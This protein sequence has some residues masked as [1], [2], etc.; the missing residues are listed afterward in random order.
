MVAFSLSVVKMWLPVVCGDYNNIFE[1]PEATAA[2]SGKIS[3][4]ICEP[5]CHKTKGSTALH[6]EFIL[7][8]WD[9][10]CHVPIVDQ[11]F[12]SRVLL[13]LVKRLTSKP[14][15]DPSFHSSMLLHH[16]YP[17]TWLNSDHSPFSH[18]VPANTFTVFCD[19]Y[20]S[21]AWCDR[22]PSQLR[23]CRCSRNRLW[24]PISR[25]GSLP[26]VGCYRTGGASMLKEHGETPTLAGLWEA[27][28]RVL[29]HWDLWL[30][31]ETLPAFPRR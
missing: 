30:P 3:D 24:N 6:T 1:E 22:R 14:A 15:V 26:F 11:C 2:L 25:Q 16:V 10:K 18:V 12:L 21:I 20:T 7:R 17:R 31:L 8:T 27:V 5:C 9:N 29:C 4:V 19:K 23:L 13:P 28:L